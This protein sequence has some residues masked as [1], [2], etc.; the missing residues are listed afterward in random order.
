MTRFFSLFLK[1]LDGTRRLLS[2]IIFAGILLLLFFAFF[3]AKPNLPDDAI[4]VL[5]PQGALLEQ[6]VQPSADAFPFA[7]PEPNQA[8]L[9]DLNLA[10]KRA[11]T[12]PAILAVRLDLQ[13]MQSSGLAKLQN[14]RESIEA[15]KKSGKPVIASGVS[16]SQAQYYIA[17]TA[18]RVFLHPMGMIEL[19]GFSVYRNYL[20]QALAKL[21][22]DV[23]VFRVGKYKSAIE[24]FMRDSMSA[25]DRDS[26]RVWLSSLWQAYKQ[27]IAQM[28][29][30]DSAHL[31]ALL[32]KPVAF[33][34]QYQGHAAALYQGEKLVDALGDDHDAEVYLRQQLKFDDDK[35]LTEIDYKDYLHFQQASPK[36]NAEHQIA[37]IVASG[38]I[39]SGN[40]P[41]GTIGSESLIELLEQ[42][43]TNNKV[44]AV[45]LR[46]DSPGGSA[47]ASELIRQ[48]LLRVKASGK[49]VIVSMGS[50]AAS[51][52]YWVA[53][54][55][56]E[57]W[58]RPTTLTGSIGVFGLIPNFSRS[59][60]TLGIHNDGV[61][62]SALAGAMRSDRPM[63]AYMA[64]II[65]MNVDDVYQRFIGIVS[66]SRKIPVEQV[67][68]IAQ[69]R[70]W[71]G[72]DAHR[73]GLLDH[74]G[75]MH[76]AILAAAKKVHI[77]DDYQLQE[78]QS[79]QTFPAMIAEQLLG[80]ANAWTHL[81]SSFHNQAIMAL[82]KAPALQ[83]TLQ[84]LQTLMQ[85][86]DPQHVYAYAAVAGQ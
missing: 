39:V 27:D 48:E 50:M 31:Q 24:P 64:E 34:K 20:S 55:A 23:H 56:D 18:N 72:V 47:V 11:A 38:T 9:K 86:N 54:A 65:Q 10:L 70:V 77:E 85:L 26:N 52:G 30:I 81:Q 49:P 5:N 8:T 69:G 51:G 7:F 78:M 46:I 1:L 75:N 80:D 42:A 61:G 74:L 3:K 16:Y 14:L 28:R 66:Q 83:N 36:A 58:A 37:L 62:T 79:E 29:G 53:S 40:Q 45:V 41:T 6:R 22:I 12:D 71:S 57:I 44:K 13:G 35:T 32:D 68:Q 73:L 21:N 59:L 76:D 19:T 15:F 33:L 25:A 84:S 82:L 67:H 63:P 60:E 2:N 43:R 17:A 4:L